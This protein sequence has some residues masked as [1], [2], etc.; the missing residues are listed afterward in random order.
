MIE[1]ANR[2]T[3]ALFELASDRDEAGSVYE[4]LKAVMDSMNERPELLRLFQSPLISRQEKHALVEGILCPG[5]TSLA[6]RFLNLLVRKNRVELLG[7][8][9]GQLEILM[10]EKKGVAKAT[11][12]AARELTE[13]LIESIKRALEHRSKKKVVCAFETDPTLLGGVQI[14]MGNRLIDG[15][16]RAKL[17]ELNQQL[18]NIKVA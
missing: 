14:R 7:E 5:S 4:K 6:G 11:I 17:N 13:N 12:V 8:I 2:Y 3:Q 10:N 15:T 1:V 16:L 9:V 18:K